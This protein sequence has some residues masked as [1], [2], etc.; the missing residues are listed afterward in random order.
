MN[1]KQVQMFA[2]FMMARITKKSIPLFISWA[3]T[4][5][6]NCRCYYCW[7]LEREE[8]ELGTEQIFAFIDA[9]KDLGTMRIHF[10]GGEP[11]LRDDFSRI[12]AHA[13]FRGVSV[14]LATNGILLPQK[15]DLLKKNID[16]VAI[17]FDGPKEVHERVK[18]KG[19]YANVLAALEKLKDTDIEVILMM[20][21]HRDNT[22]ISC[23]KYAL[24]TAHKYS[25]RIVFQPAVD[26]EHLDEG[27]AF[28]SP[29][30]A[31]YQQVMDYIIKRKVSDKG[32]IIFNSPKVLYFLKSWPQGEMIK[33]CPCGKIY[34]RIRADGLICPCGWRRADIIERKNTNEPILKDEFQELKKLNSRSCH[35]CWCAPRL[36]L[37]YI[38]NLDLRTIINACCG[39]KR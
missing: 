32:N 10:T 5:R 25:A 33:D 34:W 7:G 28:F 21:L 35:K 23:V 37:T 20:T 24:E 27:S 36:E 26:Y 17:S 16:R 15:L 29:A 13:N 30:T 6:C 8:A 39:S 2:R 31:D 18:G 4:N 12:V 11:L 3:L 19:A 14:G 9:L 22:T 38:W 1:V